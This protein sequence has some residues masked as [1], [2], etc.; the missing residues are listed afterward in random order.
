[1]SMAIFKGFKNQQAGFSYMGIMMLIM[2]SG[3]GMA[4]TGLVWH[5]RIQRHQEMQ[6]LFAGNAI[7]NAIGH[8]YT[9]NPAGVGEYPRSLEALLLDKRQPVIKRHLRRLYQDPI[10]KQQEWVLIM[11]NQRII[12]VHS[13]SSRKPIKKSGFPSLYENF[14][15]AKSYQ[16]WKFVYLPGIQ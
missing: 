13:Q 6:L 10:G 16:D 11:Q 2:I 12:G 8:Y 9:S 5:T 14:S 3:I 1:M 7:R 15:E 4:G